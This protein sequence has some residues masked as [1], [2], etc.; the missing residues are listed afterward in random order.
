MSTGLPGSFR[1]YFHGLSNRADK[2]S[3]RVSRDIRRPSAGIEAI[4]DVPCM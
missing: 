4:I 1:S 3:F 2:A